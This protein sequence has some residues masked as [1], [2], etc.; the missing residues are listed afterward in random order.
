MLI[1]FA[2]NLNTLLPS[3]HVLEELFILRLLS[4]QLGKLVALEIGCHIESW[5]GFLASDDEGTFYDAVVG[6]AIDRSGAKDV[7]ARGF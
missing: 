5:L 3:P 2:V 7:F 4:I 1:G 6:D